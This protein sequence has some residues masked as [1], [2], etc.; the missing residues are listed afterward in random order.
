MSK[1]SQETVQDVADLLPVVLQSLKAIA[2]TQTCEG[3][4]D[5][6]GFSPN[7]ELAKRYYAVRRFVANELGKQPHDVLGAGDHCKWAAARRA[8]LAKAGG[9]A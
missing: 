9:E 7:W 4:E 6:N 2:A 8:E 1:H 3:D 5:E